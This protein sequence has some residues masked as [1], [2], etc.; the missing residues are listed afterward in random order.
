[1]EGFCRL[2]AHGPTQQ[3]RDR[4]KTSGRG[5]GKRGATKNPRRAGAAPRVRLQSC[6]ETRDGLPLVLA[7]YGVPRL[8]PKLLP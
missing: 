8:E 2:F 4:R 5:E 1:M 3:E 6:N 7:V